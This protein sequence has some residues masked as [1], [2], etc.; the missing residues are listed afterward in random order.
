VGK[1]T[2]ARG[3]FSTS[4]DVPVLGT[5]PPG[6]TMTLPVRSAGELDPGDYE[7]TLRLRL[8][9]GGEEQEQ[10]VRFTVRDAPAR[11]KDDERLPWFPVL[12]AVAALAMV[13]GYALRRRL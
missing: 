11:E 7:A 5:V 6:A 13:V 9:Q 3:D 12:L 2:I 10:R 8:V 4:V 1:L